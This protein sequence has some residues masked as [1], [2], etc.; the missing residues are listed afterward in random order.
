MSYQLPLF[1]LP[2]IARG[3]E[4]VTGYDSAGRW[5]YFTRPVGASGPFFNEFAGPPHDPRS[6]CGDGEAIDE[7]GNL[8]NGFTP[9]ASY[10]RFLVGIRFHQPSGQKHPARKRRS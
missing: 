9:P 2:S 3:Q 5:K 4:W 1:K 10:R 8:V 7:F 6:T